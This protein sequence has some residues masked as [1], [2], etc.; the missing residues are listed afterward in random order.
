MDTTDS[1]SDTNTYISSNYYST[2]TLIGDCETNSYISDESWGKK[3][4]TI[5]NISNLTIT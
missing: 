3:R 1:Q 2:D 4:N 5:K